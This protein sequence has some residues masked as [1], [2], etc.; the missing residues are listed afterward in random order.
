IKAFDYDLLILDRQ[1]PGVSGLDICKYYRTRSKN[2]VLMLTG[3]SDVSSRVEGLNAGADDYLTKPFHMEELLARVRALLRR[4]ADVK[5]DQLKSGD[6]TVDLRSRIVKKGG[7]TI[8]L[9]PREYEVLEFFL[10]NQNE[11]VS[12][13]MLLKRVWSSD[14]DVSVQSVYACINRL[15]KNLDANDKEA[16]IK[17]VHGVGYRVDEI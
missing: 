16:V 3:M 10:K 11:V 5:S 6:L 12:P 17:T 4:G 9:T 13:E 14:A 8:S 1:I 15:R 2:A 7:K